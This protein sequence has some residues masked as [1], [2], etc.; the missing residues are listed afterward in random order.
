MCPNLNQPIIPDFKNN[1]FLVEQLTLLSDVGE[2]AMCP[3]TLELSTN[4]V[5]FDSI[6]ASLL[7]KAIHARQL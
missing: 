6:R 3:S 7:F 1:I 4:F 2:H 5:K